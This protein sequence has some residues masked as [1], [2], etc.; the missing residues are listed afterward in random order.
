MGG[1]VTTELEKR[2]GAGV[3]VCARQFAFVVAEDELVLWSATGS[4]FA[5][6]SPA[7]QRCAFSEA[8]EKITAVHA[9]V[10]PSGGDFDDV[11]R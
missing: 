7:T 6:E 3:G 9:R 2:S 8:F 5:G 1:L 10:K 4:V 11:P